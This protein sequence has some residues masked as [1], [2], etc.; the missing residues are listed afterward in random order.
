ML[1]DMATELDAARLL[2]LRAAALEGPR[3][4]ATRARAR[5]PSST[6]PRWR[7]RVTPQGAPDPR[8]LR[9]HEGVRRRAPLPRRAHH[10]DLRGHE[11]DPAHRD[12]RQ[13]PQ[14]LSRTREKSRMGSGSRSKR[15]RGRATKTSRAGAFIVATGAGRLLVVP[16]RP[17]PRR[18]QRGRA[19]GPRRA[20]SGSDAL[21]VTG[22]RGTLSQ[23]EVQKA[24]EPRMTKFSRCVQKRAGD[25]EWVSGGMAFEFKVGSDGTVASVYPSKSSFGDRE[26]ERCYVGDR[27]G[28]A[29]SRTP[30]G[31]GGVRLVARG[32]A[33]SARSAHLYPGPPPR[34]AP[35]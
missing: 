10:R 23:Y 2:M 8:R 13:R 18:R 22:L 26:T 28:Y 35:W 16:R 5:W 3:A 31:R 17:S 32:S 14:G 19:A 11:R 24:L 27:Q 15:A 4:C 6:P 30:R 12:R 29:L 33:R 9:L 1:A 20:G 25:V 21:S 34:L 7:S